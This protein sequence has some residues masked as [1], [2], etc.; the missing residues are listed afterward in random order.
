MW[1]RRKHCF[2]ADEML[3]SNCYFTSFCLL[4]R[5]TVNNIWAAGVFNK[6]RLHRYNLT[7]NKQL[8]KKER[9]HTLNF[10]H[11]AK[12][13]STTLIVIGCNK[14]RAVSR[15]TSESSE[16]KRFVRRWNK[17][18]RKYITKR[19]WILSTEWIRAWYPNEKM[20]VAPICLNCW[21]CF[22][23]CVCVSC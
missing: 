7:D 11:Q 9:G 10:V 15:T 18:E 5:L 22:S 14:N 4:T 16:P 1:I 2:A 13:C 20:I 17:V 3:T 8:Q 23:K 12:K 6:N 21:C 19:T